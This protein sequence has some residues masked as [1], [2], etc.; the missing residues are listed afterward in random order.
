MKTIKMKPSFE[1]L[2][3]KWRLKIFFTISVVGWQGGVKTWFE[4]LL[5]AVPSVF[6]YLLTIHIIVFLP[7]LYVRKHIRT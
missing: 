6:V 3:K 2:S 7:L 4:E 1:L 5:S